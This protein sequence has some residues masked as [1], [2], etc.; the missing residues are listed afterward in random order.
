MDQLLSR[1]GID[2]V[3][4]LKILEYGEIE[5]LGRLTN[6]SNVT[7]L[8]KLTHSEKEIQAIYKPLRGERPLHDFPAGLYKREVAAFI[9]SEELGW[10]IVPPTIIRDGPYGEG[11]LQFFIDADFEEHYFTL[12]E[13]SKFN[14]VLQKIC[15]F[16]YLINNTDRKSGH[17]LLDKNNTI[18]GIDHG[19]CF[20]SQYKLRTVIWEFAEGKIPDEILSDVDKFHKNGNTKELCNLLDPFEIDAL[21]NRT[22]ALLESKRFPQDETGGHRYPWPPV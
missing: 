19:L 12:I 5:L 8:V 7:T 11:S 18:W 17:C 13:N 6:S 16:D 3:D 14:Y 21:K 20:H 22:H 9:L 2:N 10:H 15:V 1:L 4:I